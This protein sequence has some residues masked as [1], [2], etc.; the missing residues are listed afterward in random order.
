MKDCLPNIIIL[1]CCYL[2]KG[3]EY[4]FHHSGAGNIL[5]YIYFCWLMF[6]VNVK[7]LINGSTL[8]KSLSLKKHVLC[9]HSLH[10]CLHVCQSC[11]AP[12]GVCFYF[13][14]TVRYSEQLSQRLKNMQRKGD[15]DKNLSTPLWIQRSHF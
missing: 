10:T 3:S 1:Y 14:D 13:L 4:F 15:C 11:I 9:M 6:H 8:R 7:E 5:S 2:N 12:G